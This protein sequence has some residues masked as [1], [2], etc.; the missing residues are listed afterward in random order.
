MSSTGES[1]KILI[2]DD[3]EEILTLL[4]VLLNKEGYR[5]VLARSGDEGVTMALGEGPDLVLL[6]LN[7]PGLR[8]LDVCRRIKA[9]PRTHD[10]AVII[11]SAISDTVVKAQGFNFGA[12]DYIQK[13]FRHVE[14]MARIRAQLRIKAEIDQL[15]HQYREVSEKYEQSVAFSMGAIDQL[16]IEEESKRLSVCSHVD[17]VQG[18]VNQLLIG[19]AARLERKAR[20]DLALGL[21]EMVLNAIEHG[22]LGIN[23]QEKCEALERGAFNQLIEQRQSDPRLLARRVVIDYRFDGAAV[24]YLIEDEGEGFD[25]RAYIERDESE[26][27]LASNGR[28]IMISRYVF[29]SIEYNDRGNAVTVRK[30]LIF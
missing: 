14:L 19:I 18:V 25:W 21:H 1:T 11:L 24:S 13:P 22:N 5:T 20:S 27:L 17:R 8:G 6:D 4:E 30:R 23:S 15:R 26:N 28:G 9:D 29:D 12:V 10:I 7:M 2:I 16:C 3:N